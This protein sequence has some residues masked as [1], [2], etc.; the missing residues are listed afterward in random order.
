V[1]APGRGPRDHHAA[2]RPA[3]ALGDPGEDPGHD[4]GGDLLG[5]PRLAAHHGR[6]VVTE[7]ALDL[8]HDAVGL[9]ARTAFCALADEH[10]AVGAAVGH[11]RDHREPAAERHR[12]RVRPAVAQDG[13]RRG[14][15]PEID[16]EAVRHRPDPPVTDRSVPMYRTCTA[17]TVMRHLA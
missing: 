8:A 4:R 15:R 10:G 13:G 5:G 14:R 12:L 11:R 16:A 1:I 2:G 9:V 17:A 3:L 7:A 6:H